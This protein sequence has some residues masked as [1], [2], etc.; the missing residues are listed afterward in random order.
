[1]ASGKWQVVSGKLA[2]LLSVLFVFVGVI[3][4]ERALF[5]A[6][7]PRRTW[8]G[9]PLV[10]V[11]T[12]V[13]GT[14]LIMAG[15]RRGRWLV[16]SQ[17]V[18]EIIP[19]YFA[20]TV[21]LLIN[22]IW[23]FDP[24]VDLIRSRW[25]F[26]FS[27]WLTLLIT[28]Y[29][30]NRSRI[31]HHAP[32]LLLLLVPLYWAT[33][34]RDVGSADTFEFQVT[35][36]Q[37][38][39][40]HPTGYPLF[41]LLGKLWTLLVPVQSVAMRLNIGTAIY[42]L[43]ACVIVGSLVTK[44]VEK[45]IVGIMAGV[46]FGLRPTFWSQAV[47]AEV[48]TLHAVIVAG[49]LWLLWGQIHF[50]ET[51]GSGQHGGKT[52]TLGQE[53]RLSVLG[54]WVLLAFWLG[55]G[56]TNHVTTVLLLPATIYLYL[57]NANIQT[58]KSKI[59][60]LPK[61]IVAAILPLLL[62]LYLPLRWQAVN[63]EA[64][65][66]G[67]FFQWITGSRFAGALQWRA[68]LDD[69]AR[70][71][72]I[73]RFFL[74]EWGWV[75]LTLI[76]IGF[77]YLLLQ[78][79][80]FAIALLLTWAAFSFYCLNYYV[81]DLNVFL[82]PAHLTMAIALG[83]AIP[84]LALIIERL[85]ARLRG[86]TTDWQ[87]ALG[88]IIALLLLLDVPETWRQVDQ[89]APNE[90][91]AWATAILEARLAENA[92]ILA[93]SD[94]FPPLYY[95][96]QAE[97]LRPDLE[98]MVL[99]DEAAYRAELDQRVANGQ[100]VYLARFLPRLPYPLRATTPLV[101]IAPAQPFAD[102]QT[103]EPQFIEAGIGLVDQRLELDSTYSDSVAS[104]SLAWRRMAD[105]AAPSQLVYLRWQGE[106]WTT[107][108][109]SQHPVNNSYPTAAWAVDEVVDDFYLLEKPL[110]AVAQTVEL[111][112]ALGVAFRSA[113]SLTWHT[114]ETITL[115]P[116]TYTPLTTPVRI[117]RDG[118]SVN[119]VAVDRN[120]RPEKPFSIRLDANTTQPQ[121]WPVALKDGTRIT[122][123]CF[124]QCTAENRLLENER[125]TWE[126]HAMLADAGEYELLVQPLGG[127]VRCG[128]FGGVREQCEIGRISISGV[129]LPTGAVNFD[130]KIGLLSAEIPTPQL[131]PN[132]LFEVTLN[133]QSLSTI[134]DDYTVFVQVLD[135]N[136]T[137]V[138]QVDSWPVQGTYPT[139][140]W[141]SGE[142]VRDPY[143]VQLAPEL[144]SGSYRL[145]VGF[146]RLRDLRRLPVL[147]EAGA[148]VE[149][150]F[151]VP[152]LFVP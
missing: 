151:V 114:L 92:A 76:A 74:Q 28:I 78:H 15:M 44:V 25:I 7:F 63:G 33:I 150:R 98:I 64:M 109:I 142:I 55:L 29:R 113:D 144:E 2:R 141:Q 60:A 132:G 99:P 23:L 4:A 42:A 6:V 130:D 104:L 84:A 34:G 128:W 108:P 102:V 87:L 17:A 127:N 41:L 56:M 131:T 121:D 89:S 129:P 38:G 111:Q 61:I 123:G 103:A 65:G 91:T 122:D 137:I 37:L 46:V 19:N 16:E 115:E 11:G 118:E 66:F 140:Q 100:T 35:A 88:C 149:D 39:I 45:P 73:G 47:G 69:G 1:M 133:W 8:L 147:D 86:H 143:Q 119:S 53:A 48:Y 79:R 110:V 124:E 95:L 148:I 58:L 136:D 125:Y 101:E 90:L 57:Y 12:A 81:P 83:G 93:D 106:S 72:I 54:R 49:A 5:E 126:Q 3:S 112:I 146:Y 138:G 120:S 134:E 135:E 105:L 97:G 85:H 80:H 107:N 96:Q 21:P 68:W 40:A 14:M 82:L 22:L 77:I 62:Y 50:V 71:G 52:A 32:L 139:T 27:L 59:S 18:S 152:N 30:K 24:T 26:G 9:L 70:W 67:R 31:T 145:V 94:K 116:R 117:W 20:S 75:G 51:T 36:P 43:I 13:V 10:A